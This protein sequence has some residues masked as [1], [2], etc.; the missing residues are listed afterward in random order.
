MSSKRDLIDLVSGIGD[1]S[2]KITKCL[3]IIE[4][5][6]PTN[7]DALPDEEKIKL[8]KKISEIYRSKLQLLQ[9]IKNDVSK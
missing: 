1:L 7:I 2:K 8:Y 5:K 3:E 9:K 4:T 6:L